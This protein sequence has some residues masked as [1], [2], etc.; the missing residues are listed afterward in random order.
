MSNPTINCFSSPPQFGQTIDSSM[1]LFS[2]QVLDMIFY[3]FLLRGATPTFYVVCYTTRNINDQ[4]KLPR[5]SSYVSIA[6]MTRD[7][8]FA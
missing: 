2:C 3:G 6:G 8:T 7:D 1:A 5:G 4:T